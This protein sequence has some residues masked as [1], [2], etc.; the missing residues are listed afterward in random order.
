LDAATR[1]AEGGSDMKSIVQ[2]LT[3]ALGIFFIEALL[4][5]F[6]APMN[7]NKMTVALQFVLSIA[8]ALW[9][10]KAKEE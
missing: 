6:V 3:S 9:L 8:L 2:I 4:T 7:T 10:Y 1:A 5:Y